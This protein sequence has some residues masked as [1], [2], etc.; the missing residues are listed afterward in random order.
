MHFCSICKNM[1]YLKLGEDA[2]NLT[3]YCRNCGDENDEIGKTDIF[4]SRTNLVPVDNNY[5][6]IVNQYTKYDPT[7]SR[8]TEQICPNVNCVTKT[9]AAKNKEVIMLRYDDNNLKYIYICPQCD[10]TWKN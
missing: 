6:N 8:D 10:T 1:Y 2:N 3:Y 9:D 7:L 5:K 4:V